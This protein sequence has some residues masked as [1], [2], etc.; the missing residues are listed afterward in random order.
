VAIY[1]KRGVNTTRT[2]SEFLPIKETTMRFVGY[3]N[4]LLSLSCFCLFALCSGLATASSA[5]DRKADQKLVLL[6]PDSLE[7]AQKQ[8]KEEGKK[9]LIMVTSNSCGWCKHMK[10]KILT[11]P[12]LAMYINRFYIMIEGNKSTEAGKKLIPPTDYK[13]VPYIQLLDDDG[14]ATMVASGASYY[15]SGTMAS[16]L[17]HCD[18]EEDELKDLFKEYLKDAKDKKVDSDSGAVIARL[19]ARIGKLDKVE[20][21]YGKNVESSLNNTNRRNSY[22]WFWTQQ[23]E[24]L[25]HA[26]KI[27]EQMIKNIKDESKEG[28]CLHTMAWCYYENGMLEK[29]VEILKRAKPRGSKQTE[30]FASDLKKFEDELAAK[31]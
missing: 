1:F 29:A 25:K 2:S 22:V 9:V 3:R 17:E 24:N 7:E 30:E 15:P 11:D 23:K 6:T 31:K 4:I 20:K 28:Y 19:G 12:F 21:F 16:L 13:G 14:N 27:G 8:A 26:L 18:A 5:K 10:Q